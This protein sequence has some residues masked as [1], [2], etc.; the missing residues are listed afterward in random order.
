[1]P[2]LKIVVEHLQGS[3]RG[4]RQIFDLVPCLRFGRHPENDVAFDPHRDLD[5]S[6][7][8]AE[9]RNEQGAYFLVDVGSSNGTY[10]DGERVSRVPLTTGVPIEIEF[11]PGGPYCRVYLGDSQSP[12]ATIAR[13]SGMGPHKPGRRTVAVMVQR[14]LEEAHDRHGVGRSTTFIRSMLDQAV[15]RSTV[16][17]KIIVGLFALILVGT[18]GGLV[19][20]SSRVQAHARRR[21]RELEA[22]LVAQRQAEALRQQKDEEARRLASEGPGPRIVR[23]NRGAVALLAFVDEDGVTERAF[24]TGFAVSP[25]HLAT[26][27]H[28][29]IEIERLVREGRRPFAVRNGEP[30]KQFGLKDRI[31][32]PAFTGSKV[33]VSTDVGLVEL[34]TP[35]GAQVRLAEEEALRRLTAGSRMFTYGFPGRLADPKRPEATLTE[36]V[37]GRITRFSGEVGGFEEN[38]LVQHSAFTTGGTSGSPVFDA[39]GAVIAVNAGGYVGQQSQFVLDPITNQMKVVDVGQ[40]LAG[41]NYAIRI[42]ALGS[43]MKAKG[44]KP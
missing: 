39:T 30:N 14:A 26:N 21:E 5:A 19:V 16:R 20:W 7:R 31:K 17:F 32:H 43:L 3:R 13:R 8:H 33:M 44:V 11:G 2:E 37:I 29:V 40:S 36:G 25:R 28:C 1:L 42:D 27:A 9:L 35:L 18:V 23:E 10:V 15:H 4:Q 12:P 24:C 22:Q 41:Y 6:T 34:D 38:L